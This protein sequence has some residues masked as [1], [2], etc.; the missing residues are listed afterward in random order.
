LAAAKNLGIAEV[1]IVCRDDLSEAE[2]RALALTLNRLAELGSWD[3]EALK[4]ELTF[5][6]EVEPTLDFDVS[7]TGFETPDIDRILAS[8]SHEDDPAEAIPEYDQHCTPCTRIGDIWILGDHRLHCADATE[9]ESY[10]PLMAGERAQMVCSDAP[11]GVKINGHVSGLGRHQHREFVMGGPMSRSELTSFLQTTF[12]HLAQHSVDGSIH[13][14]FMDFRHMREMLD[15]GHAVYSELKN[16]CVWVKD[17]AG[18][19]SLYRSQ[20]ELV[21]VWKNGTARHINNI[22]LGRHGRSRS[23]VWSCPGA[24][25][26]RRGRDEDLARHPTPKTVGLVIDMIKDCS[27]RN[28]VILDPFVGSGTTIIAAERTGRRCCG[29]ELDP[30]YADVSVKRWQAFTKRKAIHA[31]THLTFDQMVD[32]RPHGSAAGETVSASPPPK[33][34]RERSRSAPSTG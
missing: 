5:L 15:A 16:L 18:M 24:N 4:L 26:F 17:N 14:Q 21:F 10:V 2:A 22:E 12:G 20:H 11:Y 23:N 25:T 34:P 32:Q 27:R 28:G 7:M 9:L 31:E 19:G 30:G 1:P 3:D 29:L 8:S 13:F 6:L 33:R